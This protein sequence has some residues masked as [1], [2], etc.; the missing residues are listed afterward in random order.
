MVDGH[1]EDTESW[2]DLLRDLSERG[3]R[4]PALAVGDG[5]LGFWAALRQ[6]FPGTREQ[7]CWV[8][9]T[10]NVTP[11]LPDRVHADARAALKRIYTAQTRAAAVDAAARFT[12][13]FAAHPRATR[14][15]SDDLD[16]L[17]AF[18]DFPAERWKHL[19]TTNAI[20]VNRPERSVTGGGSTGMG[21]GG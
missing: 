12:E 2:L 6:V 7:R 5:A 3:L 21:R 19:R 18:Y 16:V 8:H 13:D 9:K 17:L 4:A 1:R 14:K 20:S 10:A 15:I 11:A